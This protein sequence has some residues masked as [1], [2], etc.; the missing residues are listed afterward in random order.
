MSFIEITSLN[1]LVTGKDNR[2]VNPFYDG[3]RSFSS[4]SLSGAKRRCNQIGGWIGEHG[5]NWI[6]P[7]ALFAYKMPNG[8]YNLLEGN[9]RVADLKEKEKNGKLS[10]EKMSKIFVRDLSDEI[11]NKTGKCYTYEEA[12]KMVKKLNTHTQT[13]H[14]IDDTIDVEC[15]LGNKI[16]LTI[17]EVANKYGISATLACDIVLG[18]SG[19]SRNNY[20]E[21]YIIE[22]D[23]R[24]IYSYY[25]EFASF[26]DKLSWENKKNDINVP[27]KSKPITPS[28]F[29][30]FRSFKNISD[31]A[32]EIF[33][34]IIFKMFENKTFLRELKEIKNNAECKQTIL[35]F[36]MNFD[37]TKLKVYKAYYQDLIKMIPDEKI[38]IIN[39]YVSAPTVKNKRFEF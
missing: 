3:E 30:L 25:D 20:V 22:A 36:F 28:L 12:E 7:A 6:S 15:G 33:K 31:E 21:D 11:N 29:D 18:I 17:R 19:S 1:Q 4:G 14:R 35:K 23:E 34:K 37:N 8:K 24:N 10:Y 27:I 26:I 13:K 38:S 9:T 16:A 2:S 32:C 39:N 5:E